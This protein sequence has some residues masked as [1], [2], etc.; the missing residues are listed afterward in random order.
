MYPTSL[1]IFTLLIVIGVAICIFVVCRELTC[2]YFKINERVDLMKRQNE[3]L[4]VIA[5]DT[6]RWAKTPNQN[7]TEKNSSPE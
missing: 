1:N 7:S 6:G 4:A 5:K 2:W 3:L